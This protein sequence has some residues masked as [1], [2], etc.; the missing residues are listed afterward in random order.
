MIDV[1]QER[2]SDRAGIRAATTAAFG[3][4]EEAELVDRLRGDGDAVISLVAV[5]GS[6]VIGHV[7]FSRLRAPF[8]S[9][10]LAPVSVVPEHQGTGVGGALIRAGLEMAGDTGWRGVFVLGDPAYYRRFGFDERLA[11][12]F[13]S[14]YS[15]PH[16]MV[17]PLG[18]AL[19]AA[20]G[21][22][23]HAPAFS[24]VS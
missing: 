18:G 20:S 9:L 7:M 2:P 13:D 1:R 8:R 16:L 14:P 19:P 23:S 12:G 22:I 10:A 17:R 6:L 15:G 3:Q 24:D 4:A 21:A 11:R 5:D